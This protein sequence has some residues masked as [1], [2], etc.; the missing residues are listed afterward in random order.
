MAISK[1]KNLK[2]SGS[3]KKNHLKIHEAN[4]HWL[5]TYNNNILTLS[6]LNGD[7]L[8]QGSPA[9]LGFKNCKKN[10]PHAIQKTI[11]HMME[12]AKEIFGVEEINIIFSGEGN[13][14]D[15]VHFLEGRVRINSIIDK[16]QVPYGG[17]P[18]VRAPRK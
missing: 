17:S 7:V 10:T 2:K 15:N 16:M 11:E 6:Q 13:G 1:Q 5:T 3:A 9:R 14:R 4:L 8:Y 18:R 12:K